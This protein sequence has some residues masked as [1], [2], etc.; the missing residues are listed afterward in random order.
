MK[1]L[2]NT[3]ILGFIQITNSQK[4]SKDGEICGG[5]L[6]EPHNCLSNL[7]CVYTSGPMIADAP[8]LCHPKCETFRDSWGECVPKNCN[9]WNDGCN[10]CTIKDGKLS[11]CTEQK[12]IEKKRQ[13]KCDSYSTDK[14]I[15]DTFAQCNNLYDLISR[16]NKVCCSNEGGECKD[17]FPHKC[18]V[19]CSSIVNVIFKDCGQITQYIGLTKQSG[20]NDFINKCKKHDTNDIEVKIPEKCST[21]YD[22]C[23]R[24]SIINGKINM[25]T[26]RMCIRKGNPY[27]L[28]Y[29]NQNQHE[30]GRQCF[31]GKDNDGDGKKDCDDPDC[32]GDPRSA[33]RCNRKR[34]GN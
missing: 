8:G 31:D 29:G 7:E 9:I 33:R 16:M 4:L 17:G 23:N 24:C 3:L 30:R 32:K 13:G 5:R 6:K 34:N 1:T 10:T 22:G 25:C 2:I 12:C 21:W 20:W 28:Q 18:S 14:P 11:K 19:E 15:K 26:M 27:C